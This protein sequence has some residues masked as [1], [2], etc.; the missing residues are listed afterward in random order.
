MNQKATIIGIGSYLPKK[1]LTNQDLEKLVETSDDWIVTRT[2]MKERRI[3]ADDEFSSTMGAEASKV[4]LKRAHKTPDDVDCIILATC[5]PDYHAMGTA[6]IVQD[7]LGAK[8]AAAFDI[9]AA[10]SGLLYG[11]MMAKSFIESGV[12]KNILVIASEKLSSITDY[13]DRSTCIL[14][15]DGAAACLVSSDNKPGLEINEIVLG[16]DGEQ[17]SLGWVPAGGSRQPASEFTLQ[18]RLHTIE[19]KGSEIFKHAVRKMEECSRNCLSK[20]NLKQSDISWI[21]PHQA[22]IRIIEALAKR[23]DFPIEKVY[24]TIQKYGNTSAS[25]IGIALEELLQKEALKKNDNLL[26]TAFGFGVTW[27]AVILTVKH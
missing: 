6:C 2:G 5:T 14:F 25:S 21:V 16:A 10:C 18:N 23:F 24:T 7:I 13:T 8:N 27:G 15:G 26:L 22:N 11:F 20:S 1:I 17:A 9:Q 12:Y 4:A 19:M 3:A